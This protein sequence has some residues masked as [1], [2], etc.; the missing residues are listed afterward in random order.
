MLQIS[1]IQK[2]QL[3]GKFLEDLH[4]SVFDEAIP[5]DYFRYDSCLV[6]QNDS[7]EIATYALIRE[8]SS[9]TIELAWGGTSKDS[10]GVTSKMALDLFTQECLNYYDN[11][12]FQTCNKNLPMLRLALSLGYI[13][14]GCRV[15]G[16][17]E[18]FLILNK[19]RV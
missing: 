14:V 11:V 13:V 7:G 9:E 6:A 12:T 3:D 17:G 16:N 5:S 2:S 8:I 1:Q 15:A 4:K 10:R 19:G 18:L